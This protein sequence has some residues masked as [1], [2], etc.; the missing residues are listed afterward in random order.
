VSKAFFCGIRVS[1]SRRVEEFN[2][3]ILFQWHFEAQSLFSELSCR[4]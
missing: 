4:K 1:I 3:F 2:N